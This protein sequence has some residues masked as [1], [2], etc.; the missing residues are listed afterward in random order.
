MKTAVSPR[1]C[2]QTDVSAE[3][4]AAENENDVR[5][6]QKENRMNTNTME[7]S[8]EEMEQV[9]GS[10]DVAAGLLGFVFGAG[11]GAAVGGSLGLAAGPVGAAV[12]AMIG[13]VAG[14]IAEGYMVATMRDRNKK[15]S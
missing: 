9:N 4:G 11:K 14:G 1:T 13:G 12:G 8:M 5:K 6:A 7:L 3:T 15:K 10:V 2:V